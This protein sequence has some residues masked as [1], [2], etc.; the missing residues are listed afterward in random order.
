MGA[1]SHVSEMGPEV[2]TLSP[3]CQQEGHNTGKVSLFLGSLPGQLWPHAS[4][5]AQ[6]PQ[7]ACLLGPYALTW[8]SCCAGSPRSAAHL[9]AQGY[10]GDT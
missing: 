2:L 6:Q 9:E 4:K 7:P 10:P 8:D 3:R 5:T 1:A